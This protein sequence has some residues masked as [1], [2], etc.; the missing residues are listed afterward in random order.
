[1]QNILKKR[2][3]LLFILI[4]LLVSEPAQIT[5]SKT[6]SGE[7]ITPETVSIT[8]SAPLKDVLDSLVNIEKRISN[9]NDKYENSN[10]SQ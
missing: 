1:M 5:N 10:E 9:I 3:M 6:V 4:V 2:L 7:V 8:S